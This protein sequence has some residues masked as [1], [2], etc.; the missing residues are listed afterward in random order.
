MMQL[1]DLRGLMHG[2]DCVVVG[3]GPSAMRA[4][5][6]YYDS[7]WTIGCNR[8]VTWCAPDF[9]VCVEPRNDNA[10]KIIKAAAPLFT[11]THLNDACHRCIEIDTD[12]SKW[13]PGIDGKL[14]LGMSPFYGA[15][16]AIALD[17]Q[18]IGLLGVD[19]DGDG[20]KY[21]NGKFQREWEQ[22]FGMLRKCSEEL[23]ITLR[24]LNPQSHLTA[25][26][27]A[28]PRDIWVKT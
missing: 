21:S 12:V 7:R 24:N 8:S 10:W 11:F 20:G 27:V 4:P 15:A 13:L 6:G 25:L 19:L 28:D 23:G 26:Q 14:K 3:A 16:V 22:A 5:K 2:Q 9:A 18:R 17:F 1:D